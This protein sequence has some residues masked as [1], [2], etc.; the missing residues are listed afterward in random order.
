MFPRKNTEH[1]VLHSFYIPGLED[2]GGVKLDI[3]V[4][5][6]LCMVLRSLAS[7][8]QKDHEVPIVHQATASVS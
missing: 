8:H 3:V 4:N 2:G 6:R 1:P 7:H 5:R